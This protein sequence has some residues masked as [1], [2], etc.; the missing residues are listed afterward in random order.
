MAVA[1][2]TA[3][4]L[5][6]R[7]QSRSVQTTSVPA[8]ASIVVVN[9]SAAMALAA[10]RAAGVEAEPAE[11]EQAGAEQRERHVVRQQRLTP[12]SRCRLPTTSAATS[13]A[14]PA[15]TC[16]TVPPAKSSAPMSASQPPPQTQCAIGA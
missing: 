12:C 5:P 9:A 11:P 14:T 8:G 6:L 15:F 13:A 10:E 16:T 4:D 3:V 7:T 2:P 1:A